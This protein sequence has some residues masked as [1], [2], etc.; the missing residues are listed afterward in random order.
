M[1]F[2]K[3]PVDAYIF[4]AW[5]GTWDFLVQEEEQRIL[6]VRMHPIQNVHVKPKKYNIGYNLE[7]I[8]L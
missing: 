3:R 1:T 6:G 8:L 7:T 5:P 4:D 2:M